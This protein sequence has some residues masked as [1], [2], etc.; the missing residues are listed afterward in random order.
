MT[1]EKK[2]SSESTAVMLMPE[3]YHVVQDGKKGCCR[4]SRVAPRTRRVRDHEHC[5]ISTCR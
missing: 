3:N 4:K 2:N 1:L 5:P